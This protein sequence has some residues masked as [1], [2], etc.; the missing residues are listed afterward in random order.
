MV[1]AGLRVAGRPTHSPIEQ[2]PET[3]QWGVRLSPEAVQM[4]EEGSVPRYTG[5]SRPQIDAPLAGS[6]RDR[7]MRARGL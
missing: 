5:P 7:A 4:I 1:R 2:E 6:A 3:E